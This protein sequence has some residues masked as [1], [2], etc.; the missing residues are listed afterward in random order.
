MNRK[1]A[2]AIFSIHLKAPVHLISVKNFLIK[3]R[4]FGI[5]GHTTFG[6]GQIESSVFP[7]TP[8]GVISRES[9]KLRVP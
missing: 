9:Q 7:N 8:D 1:G 4:Y 3:V 2:C 5:L 6:P